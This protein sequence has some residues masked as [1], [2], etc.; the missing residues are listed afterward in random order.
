MQGT[1]FQLLVHVL[2]VQRRVPAPM[3][4]PAPLAGQVCCQVIANQSDLTLLPASSHLL[5]RLRQWC[6]QQSRHMFMLFGLGWIVLRGACLH[7]CLQEQRIVHQ[8]QHVYMRWQRLGGKH[9]QH[10]FVKQI[11]LLVLHLLVKCFAP[12][13][14]TTLAAVCS[15]SAS[16]NNGGTCTS[17]GVCACKSQW[18]GTTTGCNTRLFHYVMKK[19]ESTTK[20]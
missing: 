14:Y 6:L 4:G 11:F 15:G 1:V 7:E 10:P 5:A 9:M 8:P 20:K 17:P 18:S 16:C 12:Y 3:A 2:H 13:S 19:N